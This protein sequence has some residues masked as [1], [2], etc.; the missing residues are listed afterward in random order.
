MPP[1]FPLTREDSTMR[2][3][4]IAAF[5]RAAPAVAKPHLKALHQILRKAAPKAT[6]AIKWGNPVFEAERI[7]FAFS[8]HKHHINFMP[9]PSVLTAFREELDGFKIGKGSVQLPYNQPLPRGLIRRMALRRVK[10]LRE[11]DVKWM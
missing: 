10:E 1:N 4:T 6:E 9:T 5:I 8:A 2:P 3:T 7:L 11:H